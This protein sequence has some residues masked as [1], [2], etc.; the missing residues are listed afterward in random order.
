MF[1]SLEGPQTVMVVILLFFVNT[2]W[3]PRL[4]KCVD[5]TG[6]GVVSDTSSIEVRLLL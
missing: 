3:I 2:T 4:V 1:P 5:W 6:L